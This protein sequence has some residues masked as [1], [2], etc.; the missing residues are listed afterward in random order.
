MLSIYSNIWSH[1]G[2]LPVAKGCVCVT[3][4][5]LFIFSSF[6]YNTCMQSILNCIRYL[7]FKINS[8]LLLYLEIC[9]L[10]LISHR[11]LECKY[12][13]SRP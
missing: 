10:Q 6:S 5:I 4:C 2:V 3:D 12:V 1:T 13:V 7:D 8:L 11:I 9:R